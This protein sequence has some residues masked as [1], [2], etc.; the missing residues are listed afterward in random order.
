M[1]GLNIMRTEAI[2][3]KWMEYDED[4]FCNVLRSDAPDDVKEAYRKHL[5]EQ[6]AANEGGYMAK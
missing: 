4:E 2:W 6:E 3:D 1:K 5:A